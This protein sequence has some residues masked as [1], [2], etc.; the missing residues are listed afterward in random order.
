MLRI[1]EDFAQINMF[2][3]YS[4]WDEDAEMHVEFPNPGVI[5]GKTTLV[6]NEVFKF[7]STNYTE[8]GIWHSD[9]EQVA[10]VDENGFVASVGIGKATIT[11]TAKGVYSTI[12]NSS[13]K[14]IEVIENDVV[15][16]ASDR[17]IRNEL[18]KPADQINFS[19]LLYKTMKDKKIFSNC[20][21]SMRSI[22]LISQK[23]MKT[24]LN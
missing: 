19:P 23:I 22:K 3:I 11:L 6:R 1:I 10:I 15:E 17:R 14:S 18:A 5:E 24:I 21:N 2:S 12:C 4:F 9:N 13:S 7:N 16:I 20:L 8:H